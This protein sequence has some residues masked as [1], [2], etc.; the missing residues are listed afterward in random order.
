MKRFA[1]SDVFSRAGLKT[2]E[3]ATLLGVSRVT[4]S[5]YKNKHTQPQ[6]L[7]AREVRKFVAAVQHAVEA[8]DLPLHV[9]VAKEDRLRR[10]KTILQRHRKTRSSRD[11]KLS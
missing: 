7:I 5:S 11:S 9:D 10:L 6:G 3:A 1:F 4:V 8:E 2:Q